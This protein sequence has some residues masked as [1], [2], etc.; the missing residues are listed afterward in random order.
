MMN[1]KVECSAN[2]NLTMTMYQI[3]AIYELEEKNL[4][5]DPQTENTFGTYSAIFP[6]QSGPS[7][8]P[9]ID[10]LYKN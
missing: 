3:A 2:E 4:Q 7:L 5:H 9:H 8:M 6:T 10:I 1:K